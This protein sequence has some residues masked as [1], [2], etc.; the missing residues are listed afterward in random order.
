MRVIIAGPRDLH[1]SVESIAYAVKYTG[2]T[3]TELVTGCATGIDSCGIAW[4]DANGIPKK[5]FPAKWNDIDRPGAVVR[6]RKDGTLYD[7]DAGPH[8]NGLMA[9]YADALLIIRR[10]RMSAGTADMLRQA[11]QR[12]LPVVEFI[13]D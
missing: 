9:E 1:V 13:V 7:A 5:P 6:R 12:D 3:V 11:K 8:R 4:A 2:W 10:A